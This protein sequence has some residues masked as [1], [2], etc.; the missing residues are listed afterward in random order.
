MSRPAYN[1]ADERP[2]SPFDR[3]PQAGS[4]GP[5]PNFKT[6]V[7]RNKTR[8]W[9]E[10]KQHN[11]DGD[12]W[13]GFDPYDEYGNYDDPAGPPQN[14]RP[15]QH[16][17]D[18]GEERR[19]F[20][21]GTGPP[22]QYQRGPPQQQRRDFS[23]PAYAPAPLKATQSPVASRAPAPVSSN[24]E[25]V[26][27]GSG[28][29]APAAIPF[30]R[31]SDI[32]KRMEQERERERQ[33]QESSRPSIDSASSKKVGTDAPVPP[34]PSIDRKTEISPPPQQSTAPSQTGASAGPAFTNAPVNAAPTLPDDMPRSSIDGF[35]S[36]VDRAFDR[37]DDNSVPPT[38]IS[39]RNSQKTQDDL[40]RSNSESTTGISPIMSRVP[41]S[42]TDESRGRVAAMN[43]E[44]AMSNISEEIPLEPP[45]RSA[46][47][48]SATMASTHSPQGSEGFI[49][50]HT[51]KVSTP[52]PQASPAR[53]PRLETTS[54]R[55]L[56]QPL[57]AE[58]KE[59][60]IA[61][62]PSATSNYSQATYPTSAMSDRATPVFPIPPRSSDNKSPTA[63]TPVTLRGGSRSSTPLTS[64]VE[65]R[66][67]PFPGAGGSRVR[68]LA[69]KYNDI[70]EES[71]RNSSASIKSKTSISSLR[72]KSR[73]G[74]GHAS[75][76]P[77]VAASPVGTSS[78]KLERPTYNPQPSFRPHLPGEWISTTDLRNEPVVI[79]SS[80]LASTKEE[81]DL[82]KTPTVPS[83]P[84]T[85]SEVDFT[86]RAAQVDRSASTKTASSGPADALKAAGAALAASLTTS[87]GTSHQARDFA[88]PKQEAPPTADD[89][90][91]R[92]IG[93]VYMRPLEF[94]RTASSVASSGA[95]SPPAKDTPTIDEPETRSAY[96]ADRSKRDSRD[97]W[98]GSDEEPDSV[99]S[100]RLRREIVRS[101]T[102][103]AQERGTNDRIHDQ[104]IL[105]SP[106]T[107][108]DEQNSDKVQP[109]QSSPL[110]TAQAVSDLPEVAELDGSGPE[111]A[112]GPGLLNKR[113]SW[114]SKPTSSINPSGLASEVDLP[115]SGLHVTNQEVPMVETTRASEDSGLQRRL[116]TSSA[117]PVPDGRSPVSPVANAEDGRPST[118][119]NP[120]SPI[121]AGQLER[122]STEANSRSQP[123]P[124]VDAPLPDTIEKS[125]AKI[126]SFREIA[127]IKSAPERIEKYHVTRK[128]FADMN[129]GLQG[130]LSTT[131]AAN[132]ELNYL[133]NT[134]A[135][136]VP[137]GQPTG[138]SRHRQ[139]PSII[140]MA[141]GFGSKGDGPS[142][143]SNT[144]GQST[145]QPTRRT[146]NN[147]S[148]HS[149][150]SSVNAEKMQAMGKDFLSSAGKL[151]GK[152]ITGAKGWLAKGKQRLRDSS[153]GGDKVD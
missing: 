116:S 53:S 113:F 108:R 96:F 29:K 69:G 24:E 56:S 21:A 58:V 124:I 44:R 141:K 79:Q 127:N 106:D 104:T 77:P 42:T 45:P 12:E 15:R 152:G 37:P 82:P 143:P 64:P 13:G 90:P 83:G 114:E 36:I 22:G 145:S 138:T 150:Q 128:Q 54:T 74:S 117:T 14:P 126:A 97:S 35:Q 10:A 73:S 142:S 125:S 98:E 55:R 7:N 119:E 61:E 39:A 75:P 84:S 19:A 94:Q 105:N 63:E 148:G 8:K 20:S 71:R 102:P 76:E 70:H 81:K 80:S 17:F 4:S 66:R 3:P 92:S 130:W 40:S 100:D 122:S 46:N 59:D 11:Y 99:E 41:S 139:T 48:Q 1:F 135:S 5:P 95:P 16:S 110:R 111:V 132:P 47:R 33:S 9:A 62:P 27:N 136:V 78:E 65:G 101:L 88:A 149:P 50:G 6:N 23:Q 151:G 26:D 118:S 85:P 31:P 115:Q 93:D 51:R 34:I 107:V 147:F 86:P 38:P 123:E 146:S 18:R 43:R 131:I 137:G 49:P 32:Y 30:I 133:T 103:Q 57:A 109:T 87:V 72:Q 28:G 2:S 140:K 52:S 68:D 112:A 153:G 91:K 121:G 120:P 60:E 25:D 134:N 144:D 89:Q 67:S 129:T